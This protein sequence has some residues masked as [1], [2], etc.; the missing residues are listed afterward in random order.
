M[1]SINYRKSVGRALGE[2]W[3][4]AFCQAIVAHNLWETELS[5]W[6]IHWIRP[7]P[8]ALRWA[9]RC[10]PLRNVNLWC[11]MHGDWSWSPATHCNDKWRFDGLQDAVFMHLVDWLENHLWSTTDPEWL[12]CNLPLCKMPKEMFT[13]RTS[14]INSFYLH[15]DD[16]YLSWIIGA[17]SRV[18][19]VE[20]VAIQRWFIDRRLN[21]IHSDFPE[22]CRLLL[23]V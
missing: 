20:H 3:E 13:S 2:R 19:I 6:C 22:N 17:H 15:L 5:L 21:E 14:S 9:S 8:S 23:S 7:D 1:H 4:S 16:Y 12:Y 18:C 11:W 10:Q